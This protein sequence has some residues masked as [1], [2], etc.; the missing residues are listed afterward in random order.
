MDR[1][2]AVEHSA[3][4]WR[5]VTQ[6]NDL[7][8]RLK[9]SCT[10]VG[11]SEAIKHIMQCVA[12]VAPSDMTV[13]ILGESGTGKDVVAR[14]IHES[15]GKNPNAYVKVNCPAIPETLLE[16]ELFGHEPGAFTGADRRKPGRF[17]LASGGTIFLD[18]I[19]NLSLSLQAKLL[20]VIE[21]KRFSRLGGIQNI[22]VDIRII[23]ATNAPI[24]EM[25]TQGRFRTDVY[26]RLNEYRI[27]MPPLRQ[28]TE[29]I[30]LLVQ[31]FLSL[32]GNTYGCPE[33]E[34]SPDIMSLL[35]QYKW[36]GNV[37]ELESLIQRFALDG[38]ENS[39]L[40]SLKGFSI[41]KI[42]PGVTEAVRITET[43]AIL[44]ALTEAKWNQRKAAE[45]LGISYSSLRRRI[46]K[47]KMKE[48]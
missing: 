28:R 40:E 1:L 5:M 12:Q 21:E 20:Q 41:K 48:Q 26:Y 42:S 3:K 30:P 24:E 34:I 9:G 38:N 16:S 17:E 14:L 22:D 4:Q 8:R 39:I 29:D 32:Y 2:R 27:E 47:Y 33:L 7:M 23:A 11:Q 18:E 6:N 13:F 31:H 36:P 43:Q 15:S 19:G 35:I 46:D 44:A 25:V 37:R 45:L 10:L